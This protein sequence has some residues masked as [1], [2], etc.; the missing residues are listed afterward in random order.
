MTT[1]RKYIVNVG[2]VPEK[3]RL[4][5]GGFIPKNCGPINVVCSVVAPW[6]THRLLLPSLIKRKLGTPSDLVINTLMPGGDKKVT[7]T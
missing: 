1:V 5:W 2:S 4:I 7:H 3:C 6:S